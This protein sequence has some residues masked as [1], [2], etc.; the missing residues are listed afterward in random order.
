[1]DE[2]HAEGLQLLTAQCE[3]QEGNL[4]IPTELTSSCGFFFYHTHQCEQG[5]TE[6]L[7]FY[8]KA[9]ALHRISR[10]TY[11]CPVVC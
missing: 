6:A 3:G 7:G 2:L 1:M 8:P 5:V 10:R 11:M 9:V 4:G